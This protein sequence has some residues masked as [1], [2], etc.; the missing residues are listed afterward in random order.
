VIDLRLAEPGDVDVLGELTD[1]AYRHYVPRIGLR[2]APMDADFAGLVAAGQVWVA[3]QDAAV[4]GLIVLIPGADHLLVENVA[5]RPSAQGHG[6]G[7]RLMSW[8]EEEAIRRGLDAVTLY[9]HELMTENLAFYARRGYLVTHRAE[10]DRF[11]R[12]FL[13]K[14]LRG[15]SGPA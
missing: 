3:V 14:S 15:A 1:E 5:V 8:A 2:P 6:V 10:E 9:T 13:R 4:T 12:V 11:R 7:L